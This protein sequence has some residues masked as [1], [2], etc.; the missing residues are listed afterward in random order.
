MD[1]WQ[2]VHW[3]IRDNTTPFQ[4]TLRESTSSTKATSRSA[5][6]SAQPRSFNG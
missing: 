6:I 5:A 4:S 1:K 2:L 3:L